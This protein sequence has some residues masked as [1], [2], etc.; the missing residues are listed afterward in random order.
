MNVT[1]MHAPARSPA[2]YTQQPVKFAATTS[3]P[4]VQAGFL[5]AP[6][7]G[8][9]NRPSNATVAIATT[10]A[11]G[12][13]PHAPTNRDLHRQQTVKHAIE[14][15]VLSIRRDNHRGADP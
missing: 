5:D 3:G 9:A 4:G 2:T 11:K 12:A 10:W 7:T 8:L 14:R 1:A 13:P 6:L 15:H